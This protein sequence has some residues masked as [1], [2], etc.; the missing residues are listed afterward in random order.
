M[1]EAEGANSKQKFASQTSEINE[2]LSTALAIHC[3]H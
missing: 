1:I 3:F 2:K